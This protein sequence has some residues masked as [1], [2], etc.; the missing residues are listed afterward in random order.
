VRITWPVIR[1][2]EL[3]S[4]GQAIQQ[5]I[6]GFDVATQHRWLA[7]ETVIGILASLFPEIQSPQMEQADAAGN[8]E[9]AV[10]AQ[11][12]ASDT[13]ALPPGKP[14]NGSGSKSAAKKALATTAASRS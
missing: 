13:Q 2:D 9:P 7:D 4:K 6:M 12:P 11:A 8:F 14:T 1:T 10:P 5:L 3:V